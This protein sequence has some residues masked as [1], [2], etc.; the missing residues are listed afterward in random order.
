[1]EKIRIEKVSKE[2]FLKDLNDT[3]NV[4]EDCIVDFYGFT[5]QMGLLYANCGISPKQLL[6]ILKLLLE[7][8]K[9]Y[10]LLKMVM[11]G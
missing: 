11:K 1:M 5:E 7:I 2:K 6:Y 9:S 10:N 3:F 4:S 8:F